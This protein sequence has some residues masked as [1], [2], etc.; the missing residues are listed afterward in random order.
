[1]CVHR[2]IVSPK[3]F[4]EIYFAIGRVL[5]ASLQKDHMIQYSIFIKVFHKWGVN[6][7][8]HKKLRV[9]FTSDTGT[10]NYKAV[11]G[12]NKSEEDILYSLCVFFVLSAISIKVL[13]M[14]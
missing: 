13:I 4:I 10:G 3:M 2:N 14:L 6:Q 12:T 5:R 7:V 8:F 9:H 11:T 1:M